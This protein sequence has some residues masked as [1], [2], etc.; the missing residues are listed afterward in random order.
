MVAALPIRSPGEHGGGARQDA[1]GR[2]ATGHKR[3]T[4][5]ILTSGDGSFAILRRLAQKGS[6]SFVGVPKTIDN[7][8]RATEWSVG[9]QTAV[10][11]ATEALDRLQPTA[12][13]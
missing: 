10:S 5:G 12:A 4:I 8:L 11:V 3:K 13:S 1:G 9:Y 2:M 6:I 7:D